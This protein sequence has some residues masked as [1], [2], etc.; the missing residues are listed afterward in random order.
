M[1]S[2]VPTRRMVL[3]W[4][5]PL[6]V[7]VF[8][9]AFPALRAMV[10]L[11]DAGLAIVALT[12]ALLLGRPRLTAIRT[13]KPTWSINRPERV[14]VEL[15]LAGRRRPVALFH[16]SLFPGAVAEGLPAS[17]RLGPASRVEYRV[18]AKERGRVALGAHHVRVTSPLGLWQRQI[19]VPAEDVIHVWPDVKALSHYDLLARAGR[20]A[21]MLRVV[22]RPGNLAEFER[23]RPYTRGDEYRLVDWKATARARQPMV[24]QLRHATNQNIVF[25]LDL[26]RNMTATWDGR[27]AVDAALD[28]LLLT[29]HVALRQ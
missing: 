1:T 26:G 16:Q 7:A 13:V 8:A 12:D 29:G 27:S 23:L 11:V 6:G 5:L 15:R 24:R 10:F 19:D 18:T 17:L 3:L 2:F 14:V 20:Q 22:R 25:L 21:L 4:A 28:A 9:A